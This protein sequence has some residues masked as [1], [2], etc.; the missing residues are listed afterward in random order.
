VV[1]LCSRAFRALEQR[2]IRIFYKIFWILAKNC[3]IKASIAALRNMPRCSYE[4]NQTKTQWILFC[5]NDDPHL[6][7]GDMIW[8]SPTSKERVLGF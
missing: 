4:M 3:I 7:G 6:S 2:Q 5:K 8:V 1:E